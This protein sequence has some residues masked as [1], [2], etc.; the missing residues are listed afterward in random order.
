MQKKTSIPLIIAICFG[1]LLEYYDIALYTL[2]VP[3]LAPS[4]FPSSD[5]LTALILMYA[6]LPL[7][8][9]ARPLGSLFFGYFGDRLGRKKA[10]SFSL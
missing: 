8:K 6:I 9:I 10:I 1:N 4:I 7:G 2:L 5:P 3:F